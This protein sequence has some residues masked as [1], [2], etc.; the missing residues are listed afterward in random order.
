MRQNVQPSA[1]PVDLFCESSLG[2]TPSA[3]GS[4]AEIGVFRSQRCPVADA[5]AAAVVAAQYIFTV[6]TRRIY[7]AQAKRGV[8]VYCIAGD[9]APMAASYAGAVRARRIAG[10]FSL[11]TGR[12]TDGGVAVCCA[13]LNHAVSHFNAGAICCGVH[14]FD[15]AVDSSKYAE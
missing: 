9:Q 6:A 5:C 1:A 14:G 4:I 3:R 13:T 15:D 8:V 12:N 7:E 2:A 11:P 10:D